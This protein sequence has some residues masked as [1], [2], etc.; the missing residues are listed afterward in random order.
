MLW[1]IV[2]S[3]AILVVACACVVWKSDQFSYKGVLGEFT[4]KASGLQI[5]LNNALYANKELSTTVNNLKKSLEELKN[6]C[7]PSTV[8]GF[9]SNKENILSDK[10][11]ELDKNLTH[12]SGLLNQQKIKL[13]DISK[14]IIEFKKILQNYSSKESN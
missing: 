1:T 11:I 3:V 14:D 10:F 8:S 9:T 6:I 12:Q 4:V 7:N 2:C 5:Q 13:E